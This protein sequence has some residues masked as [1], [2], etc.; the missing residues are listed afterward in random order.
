LAKFEELAAKFKAEGN[1]S[2]KIDARENLS[3]GFK[4][5][6]WELKGIPLRLEMGPRDLK[7]DNVVLVRRD[8]GEKMIV[9]QAELASKIPALLEEIHTSLFATAKKFQAENTHTVATYEEF[10]TS[11]EEKGGFHLVYFAGTPEDEENIQEE[12]KATGRCTPL[13][14]SG[15][16]GKCF[17]TGKV[18]NQQVIFARAY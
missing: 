7:S 11:I 2:F 12:T 10:K 15:E 3:P 16:E 18:T 17:Y 6:D 5:S 8:T 13:E 14:K 4:F 1:F 9:P